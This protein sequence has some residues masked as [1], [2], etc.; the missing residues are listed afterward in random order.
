MKI[1]L[2]LPLMLLSLLG[3][4]PMFQSVVPDKATLLQ[5]GNA[6]NYCP[7][8]AM[9]LAKYYKTSHA[10]K[11]KDG[12]YRQFCSIHC[13]VEESE[14]GFLRDKKTKIAEIL[15]ADA[16]GLAMISVEKAFYVIG[17]KIPGT[18]TGN[19]KYAFA[20][21]ADAQTFQKENGGKLATY[22]EA[23]KAALN[24]FKNDIQMMKA[25]KDTMIYANGKNILENMCDSNKVFSIHASNIGETKQMIKE[26]GACKADLND[27]Q[28]QALSLYFWDIKLG[29]FDKNYKHLLT[30]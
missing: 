10:V 14:M 28:L 7:N 21:K 22:N 6:K 19:S 11:F 25:K 15:V 26:S 3:A 27:M 9:D 12:T 5:K 23:Y 20:S 18:M 4:E 29:N 16:K 17:S 1:F 8:C 2:I 30:K 13:L 24:D